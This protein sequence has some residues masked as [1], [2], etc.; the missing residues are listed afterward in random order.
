MPKRSRLSRYRNADAEH[1]RNRLDMIAKKRAMVKDI[2]TLSGGSVLEELE[3]DYC[4]L[5][6]NLEEKL[7][8][9]SPMTISKIH[10]RIID[11]EAQPTPIQPEEMF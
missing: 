1:R 11:F 7:M 3:E 8:A 4:A 5:G 10:K 9:L 6:D 2:L